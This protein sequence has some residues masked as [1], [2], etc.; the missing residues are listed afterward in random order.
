MD[1]EIHVVPVCA[2]YGYIHIRT[3][4]IDNLVGRCLL[5][6]C[7]DSSSDP[8]STCRKPLILDWEVEAGSVSG[9]KK[10]PCLNK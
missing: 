10:R 1:S 3:K 5:H 8:Q 2:S 6:K 9:L 7:E 4:L